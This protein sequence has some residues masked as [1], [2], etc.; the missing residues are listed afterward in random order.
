MF[1]NWTYLACLRK[2]SWRKF[3]FLTLKTMFLFPHTLKFTRQ[4]RIAGDRGLV[5]LRIPCK[6]KRR[7]REKSVFFL[8]FSKKKKVFQQKLTG[9][10]LFAV[11]C[12]SGIFHIPTAR[13]TQAIHFTTFITGSFPCFARKAKR[14]MIRTD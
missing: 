12:L 10:T 1:A 9:W 4:T 3:T 2:E 5:G 11:G 6:K 7:E 13:T 8:L 14:H